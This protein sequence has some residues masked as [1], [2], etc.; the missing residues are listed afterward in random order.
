M[1]KAHIG[2]SSH[3]SRD[4]SQQYP[5][6]VVIRLD[7]RPAQRV[8]R[9]RGEGD[10]GSRET[11][12]HHRN[13]ACSLFP[14]KVVADRLESVVDRLHSQNLTISQRRLSL[15]SRCSGLY[16][17]SLAL[18]QDQLGSQLGA[19]C[20]G[21]FGSGCSLFGCARHFSAFGLEAAAAI[22][23]LSASWCPHSFKQTPGC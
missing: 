15:I 16:P 3:K 10:Q 13:N 20:C 2:S 1:Q 21:L 9:K 4:C 18:A 22:I 7:S 17:F 23:S 11:N 5:P 14:S 12:H 19:Q 8:H 6:P